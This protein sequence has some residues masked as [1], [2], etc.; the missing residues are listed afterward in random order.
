MPAQQRARENDKDKGQEE[1]G[2]QILL[3]SLKGCVVTCATT[4]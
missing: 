1:D 3:L 2:L 4:V